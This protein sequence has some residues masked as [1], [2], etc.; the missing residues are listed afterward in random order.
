[1]NT[2]QVYEKAIIRISYSI[3]IVLSKQD[4]KPHNCDS[5]SIGLTDNKIMIGKG[6]IWH[7]YTLTN[8]DKHFSL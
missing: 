4:W 7:L 2:Y 1:M 3:G 6:D 8:I 5:R